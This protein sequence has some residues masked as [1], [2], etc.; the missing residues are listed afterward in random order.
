MKN[1]KSNF[2][3]ATYLLFFLPWITKEKDPFVLYHQRQAIILAV[4]GLAGQ[5]VIGVLGWWFSFFAL[6]SLWSSLVVILLWA[7][8][9]FL[10]YEVVMGARAAMAGEMKTLP[11]I[12]KFVSGL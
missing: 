9:I 11:W 4:A 12:G 6:W 1:P 7:L 10:V 8:R 3:A 5:G 2:A